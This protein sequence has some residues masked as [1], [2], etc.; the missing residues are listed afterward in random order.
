MKKLIVLLGA[1]A[2][3]L[4][5]S[6][7]AQAKE[8]ISLKVCGASICVKSTDQNV[9]KGWEADGEGDPAQI[10]QT[11]PSDY[12]KVGIGFGDQGKLIHT[13]P[14]YWLPGR[15]LMR[16]QGQYG[17]PWWRLFPSQVK[18]LRGVAVDLA[19]IAPTL[20]WVKVGGKQ[21]SD[22]SSYLRLL[23]KFH[24]VAVLPR[25]AHRKTVRIVLHA[26]AANPWI[27]STLGLHYLPKRRLL[28]R[29]SLGYRVPKRM[30]RRVMRRV[31]LAGSTP[32]ASRSPSRADSTAL[33]AGVGAAGLVAA[34]GLLLVGGTV[35]KARDS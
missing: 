28:V 26:P 11:N 34:L 21:V 29:D 35:R 19:P 14:G 30:A 23:G 31:S 18:M 15:N 6:A 8:I 33:Y 12:Y 3:L 32:T 13:E 17:Y 24:E 25:M 1:V 9:L 22:P 10:W 2:G 20:S 4:A 7:P 27:H 16:F 5:L